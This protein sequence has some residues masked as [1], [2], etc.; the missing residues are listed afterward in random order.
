M[1]TAGDLNVANTIN[2]TTGA[3]C[4]YVSVGYPN[5]D[6]EFDL[7]FGD[8]YFVGMGN[9]NYIYQCTAGGSVTGG[10]VLIE[11][12]FITVGDVGAQGGLIVV[13]YGTMDATVLKD[14]GQNVVMQI[15]TGSGY[16]TVRTTKVGAT[17]SNGNTYASLPVAIATSVSGVTQARFKIMTGKFLISNASTSNSSFMRNA[18][19][20]VLGA[21]R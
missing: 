2:V 9:G 19:L 10:H 17:T 18:T 8:Y 21:K 20:S 13:F 7:E 11:T 16:E 3:T 15:D 5:G 1:Y 4:S 6:Y 12:P 14:A